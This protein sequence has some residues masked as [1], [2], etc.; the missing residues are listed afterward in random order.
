MTPARV[1]DRVGC[2]V[3]HVFIGE[4]KVG[5]DKIRPI[6]TLVAHLLCNLIN[7]FNMWLTHTRTYLIT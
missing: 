2:I 1:S 7:R 6:R 5:Y 3:A 4:M